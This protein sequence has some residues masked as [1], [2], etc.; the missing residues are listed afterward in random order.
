M[1]L[2]NNY[3]TPNPTIDFATL[4]KKNNKKRRRRSYSF[5]ELFLGEIKTKKV[6][7]VYPLN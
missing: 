3:L 4:E 6:L 7:R 1:K 5:I 2:R